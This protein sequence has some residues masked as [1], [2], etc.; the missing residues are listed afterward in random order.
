MHHD[1]E[2]HSYTNITEKSTYETNI[3]PSTFR[4][5]GQFWTINTTALQDS[6]VH[7][8]KH[9]YLDSIWKFCR[10]YC[11]YSLEH[12]CKTVFLK[13]RWYA[14]MHRPSYIRCAITKINI[15]INLKA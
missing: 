10:G 2:S 1:F 15:E 4:F 9:S 6:F 8:L 11:D 5:S 12:S 3:K 13:L 7:N 14:K